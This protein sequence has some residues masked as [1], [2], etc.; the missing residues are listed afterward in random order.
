MTTQAER[1]ADVMNMGSKKEGPA[2]VWGRTEVQRAGRGRFGVL[3][4]PASWC[5]EIAE[6]EG[7]R[8]DK[9]AA[10]I[11]SWEEERGWVSSL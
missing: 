1:N 3:R 6:E 4:N 5:T 10:E 8:P 7:G 9:V 11:R 2:F